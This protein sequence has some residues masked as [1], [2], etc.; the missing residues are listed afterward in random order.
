MGFGA[1][2][3]PNPARSSVTT[4]F[5]STASASTSRRYIVKPGDVV[6]VDRPRPCFICACKAALEAAESRGFRSGSRSTSRKARARSRPCRSA[7]ELPSTINERPRHRTVLE[8]I[9]AAAEFFPTEEAS[10]MQSSGLLKPRIID[11]QSVSPRARQG[12]HGAVRTRL[13]PYA[14]Q[15]P[16]SY[17]AVLDAR[18]CADRSRID[19]VLH[20]Y[21]T[22]DGVQEDVV[23]ILLN[24]KGVV[25]KL[26]NRDEVNLTLKEGEGAVTCRL[27]SR[28]RTTSRSSTRNTSLRT[29][30]RAASC[31]TGDQ[32]RKGPWL[33]SRQHAQS[34]RLEGHRQAGAGRFVQP[35]R[36]V[37]Y[38]VESARV[39]QRTDLDKLIIDIETNG[40]VEPEEADPLRCPRA[41]G[42]AVGLRRS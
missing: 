22:V 31:R 2:R 29:C 5:W 27:T 15:C 42:T 20:E 26:H 21:S 19:G 36:R 37:A 40:V 11:V 25:F 8:V 18:L 28:C 6:Q 12:R 24:L 4:A 17:P 34:W 39:E 13:R 9:R 38:A 41:D 23:D 33:C 16:A 30:R 1:S 7:A 32:G 10:L 14:R 35:V 3:G